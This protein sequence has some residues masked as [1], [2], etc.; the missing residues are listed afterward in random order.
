MGIECIPILANIMFA[1]R[2]RK[3]I[4]D[5]TKPIVIHPYLRITSE[6]S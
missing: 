5:K 4:T 3:A 2:N 6:N 1:G